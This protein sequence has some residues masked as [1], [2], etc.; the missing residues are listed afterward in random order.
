MKSLK[1]MPLLWPDYSN[2]NYISDIHSTV[3]MTTYQQVNLAKLCLEK[4]SSFK[5]YADYEGIGDA[6]NE[7][8]EKLTKD[9]NMIERK[10]NK[11]DKL[12]IKDDVPEE[13]RKLRPS[14][15]NSKSKLGDLFKRVEETIDKFGGKVLNKRMTYKYAIDTQTSLAWRYEFQKFIA[16]LLISNDESYESLLFPCSIVENVWNTYIELGA[17]YRKFSS[18]MFPNQVINKE[19]VLSYQGDIRELIEIYTKTL[20]QYKE[21]FNCDPE[22]NGWDS[23]GERFSHLNTCENEDED[24]IVINPKLNLDDPQKRIPIN[25]FRLMTIIVLRITT[26]MP[27]IDAKII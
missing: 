12:H 25:I 3:W 15:V 24:K 20:D 5:D 27:D 6:T 1:F 2:E 16:F 22:K 13:I 26:K 17:Y 11:C 21:L 14:F 18:V 23:A 4:S 19:S 9:S 8:I 7:I 10:C